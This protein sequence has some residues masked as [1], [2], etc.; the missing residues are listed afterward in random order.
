M[1]FCLLYNVVLENNSVQNSPWGRGSISSSW[2]ISFYHFVVYLFKRYFLYCIKLTLIKD[3]TIRIL[4]P[5]YF[6]SIMKTDS[7]QFQC[8]LIF[9]ISLISMQ[10]FPTI[11]LCTDDPTGYW[12]ALTRGGSRVQFGHPPS[13]PR[14]LII[15]SC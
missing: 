5:S 10:T 1:S 15:T 4:F 8:T 11:R 14:P 13:P 2:S 3:L 9:G 12:Y 7:I 6:P